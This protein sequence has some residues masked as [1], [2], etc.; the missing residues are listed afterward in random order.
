[1]AGRSGG[2]AHRTPLAG[3]RQRVIVE[4]WRPRHVDAPRQLLQLVVAEE[5]PEDVATGIGR[6]ACGQR[7]VWQMLSSSP[8]AQLCMLV[9]IS[10]STD[11]PMHISAVTSSWCLTASMR[12]RGKTARHVQLRQTRGAKL[13]PRQIDPCL[14][15]HGR[16]AVYGYEHAGQEHDL[17][18]R[19]GLVPSRPSPVQTHDTGARRDHER[20]GGGALA[21]QRSPM[22]WL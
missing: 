8:T 10:P 21:S 14:V 20:S 9:Q 22:R 11:P 6:S 5:V 16:H 4:T 3:L 12:R 18:Q 19:L 15:N 17:E 2:I 13:H 7:S 1:M